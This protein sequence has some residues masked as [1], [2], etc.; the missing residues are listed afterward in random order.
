MEYVKVRYP[1]K[2]DVYIDGQQSGST[3][4]VLIVEVGHHSFTLGTPADYTPRQIDMLVSGTTAEFPAMVV[5]TP[6][7]G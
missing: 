5:F 2:R 6:V 1:M 3:N 7:H 4:E